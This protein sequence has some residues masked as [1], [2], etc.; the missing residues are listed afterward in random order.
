MGDTFT[1]VLSY[2]DDSTVICFSLRGMNCML[3]ICSEFAENFSL[4]FNGNKSMCIKLGENVTDKETI[5][6][7]DLQIVWVKDVR[8]LGNYINKCVLQLDSY[9][10]DM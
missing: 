6:L 3:K 9:K 4:T 8:H 1:G 10:V 7:N 2:A 5:M